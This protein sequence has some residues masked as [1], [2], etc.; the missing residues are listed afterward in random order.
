MHFSS[1][2]HLQA[3]TDRAHTM[4]DTAHGTTVRGCRVQSV[5]R[6]P[7]THTQRHMHVTAPPAT[8]ILSTLAEN[9]DTERACKG[10][11]DTHT[12][13]TLYTGHTKIVY[14][15]PFA[16][17]FFFRAPLTLFLCVLPCRVL[18]SGWWGCRSPGN[19]KRCQIGAHC[20]VPTTTTASRQAECQSDQQPVGRPTSDP[21]RWQRR[22]R[23]RVFRY[24]VLGLA[25]R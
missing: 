24:A 22:G 2:F 23:V 21:P 8:A 11:N 10:K 13:H 1:H 6:T 7:T 19:S 25:S 4:R 17:C 3:K 15:Q 20:V 5:S 16:C 18:G 9:R 14:P 12:P